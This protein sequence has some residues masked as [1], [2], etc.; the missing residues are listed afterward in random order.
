MTRPTSQSRPVRE[1]AKTTLLEPYWRIFSM[2]GGPENALRSAKRPYYQYR[3]DTV[4]PSSVCVRPPYRGRNTLTAQTHGV[5]G[6]YWA[7]L[8]EP[9]R[10]V[11]H[12]LA[13]CPTG[14]GTTVDAEHL[15]RGAG[16]GASG[17]FDHLSRNHRPLKPLAT[18][19]RAGNT[20]SETAR[21]PRHFAGAPN[22]SSHSFGSPVFA[23]TPKSPHFRR[24][25]MIPHD[26]P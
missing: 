8:P 26:R 6:R 23:H 24:A 21:K 25:R 3:I 1:Q 10:P 9:G 19:R 18:A 4:W 15:E 22:G 2:A 16:T 5:E 20:R 7:R 17:N 12:P 11:A 13:R 14:I